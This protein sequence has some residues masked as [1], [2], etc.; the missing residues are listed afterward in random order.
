MKGAIEGLKMV[1]HEQPCNVYN[2]K[3]ED[4]NTNRTLNF[5]VSMAN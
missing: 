3:I 5:K 2:I 4:T 1:G